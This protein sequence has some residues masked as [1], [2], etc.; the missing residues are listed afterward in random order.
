MA[1]NEITFKISD[2]IKKLGQDLEALAPRI[3]DE[4]NGIVG[5]LAKATYNQIVAKAQMELHS[6]RLDY[7][8]GL[9]F[10]QVGPN[11]YMISLDGFFA[12]SLEDGRP[13]YSLNEALLKSAKEVSTGS[14][15]GEPWVRKNKQGKRYAA[16]P[17]EQSQMR[18]EMGLPT[19]RVT[20]PFTDKKQ[21]INQL[22]KD[23][24]KNIIQGKVGSFNIPSAPNELQGLT[25]YQHTNKETGKTRSTY[26]TF[27]MI[28]ENGK[29][30]TH[31]GF[32]GLHAFEEAMKM[33]DVQFEKMLN[34][35]FDKI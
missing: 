10:Q 13:P 19:L 12:N 17:F 16:V 3:R 5:D 2:E 20:N 8:R 24:D 35:L 18:V 23:F 29:Q 34:E 33:V 14:R 30:W 6:T 31:P 15:A 11:D 26:V 32:S 4:L 25:K 22:F 7:L 21:K 27:R 9:Q 1:S 28:S